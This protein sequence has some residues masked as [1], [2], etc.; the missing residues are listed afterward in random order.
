M[1]VERSYY[2][3]AEA[4]NQELPLAY[5]YNS[6]FE[7]YKRATIDFMDR[8]IDTMF[9]PADVFTD[10]NGNPNLM[11]TN[12]VTADNDY[13]YIKFPDVPENDNYWI[14]ILRKPLFKGLPKSA[15]GG[16]PVAITFGGLLHFIKRAKV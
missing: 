9:R 12:E 8:T 7:F 11:V 13:V 14:S 1:S 5:M 2:P 15:T 3:F 16:D 10:K 6:D 4:F